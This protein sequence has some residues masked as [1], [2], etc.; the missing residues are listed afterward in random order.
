[1]SFYALTKLKA[2]KRRAPIQFWTIISVIAL[3]CALLFSFVTMKKQEAIYIPKK[4]AVQTRVM[5]PPPLS[6]KPV[7]RASPKPTKKKLQKKAPSKQ[8][9]LLQEVRE[10][11]AKI[12]SEQKPVA[13]KKS[14]PLPTPIQAPAV[15]ET[16]IYQDLLIEILKDSLKL[17]GYGKVTIK[18]TLSHAGIVKGVEVVSSESD[19]NQTFLVE[20]L[21]KLQF[22]EFQGDLK[23][24][25]E[26]TFLLTF[27][28]H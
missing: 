27:C 21:E 9:K 3:H 25:D 10:K 24:A 7:K 19:Q 4:I 11:L 26:Q 22:P 14:L 12:E 5:P 18:L 16:L 15:Q 1:M 17:P 2:W 6:V 8:K 13:A 28:N 23:K 20:H